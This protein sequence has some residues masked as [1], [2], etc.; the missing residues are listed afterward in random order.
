[1][2]RF[3]QLLLPFGLGIAAVAFVYWTAL[4]YT[5]HGM[6]TGEGAFRAAFALGA[7]GVLALVLRLAWWVVGERPRS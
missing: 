1:M 6:F 4:G 5:Y 7:V 3:D 2:P